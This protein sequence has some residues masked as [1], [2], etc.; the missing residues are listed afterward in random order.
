MDKTDLSLT[1]IFCDRHQDFQTCLTKFCISFGCS[2]YLSHRL[3]HIY[4]GA[5]V[6]T[7]YHAAQ[8]DCCPPSVS[9]IH[10][11]MEMWPLSDELSLGNG[12]VK[13][14]RKTTQSIH[15]R[16]KKKSTYILSFLSFFLFPL[17]Y[18]CTVTL[19]KQSQNSCLCSLDQYTRFFSEDTNTI[20]KNVNTLTSVNFVC[21]LS[22]N[23]STLSIKATSYWTG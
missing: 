3:K 20:H 22:L 19:W 17:K 15:Q 8:H 14:S 21:F 7:R 6:H 2:L 11:E 12:P 5:Q 13:T 10:K 23:N 18:V 16:K 9:F 1:R 4:P